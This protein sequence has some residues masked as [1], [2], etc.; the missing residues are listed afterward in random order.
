MSLV[1]KLNI[2]SALFSG[3]WQCSTGA[4]VKYVGSIGEFQVLNIKKS[5]YTLSIGIMKGKLSMPLR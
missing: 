4:C 1:I 5:G 3:K 2:I